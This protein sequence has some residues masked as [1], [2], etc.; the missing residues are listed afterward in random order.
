MVQ[1]LH[2]TYNQVNTLHTIDV[3]D[4]ACI[5]TLQESTTRNVFI[6]Q[7]SH[8]VSHTYLCALSEAKLNQLHNNNRQE[9]KRLDTKPNTKKAKR[10]SIDNT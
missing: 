6:T 5:A 3:I 1:T 4:V 7:A 9:Q 2:P 8:E 10:S